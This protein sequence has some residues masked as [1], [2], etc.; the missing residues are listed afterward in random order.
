MHLDAPSGRA[1]LLSF[2]ATDGFSISTSILQC[3]RALCCIPTF[4][5]MLSNTT[6]RWLS[7]STVCQ[8]SLYMMLS[9]RCVAV[10][11]LSQP[12]ISSTSIGRRLESTST[13]TG[14]LV[15]GGSGRCGWVAREALGEW[16]WVKERFSKWNPGKWKHGLKPA[17]PGWFSF[18][19][20]PNGSDLMRHCL[21]GTNCRR[22]SGG[23]WAKV[24]LGVAQKGFPWLRLNLVAP[25][26]PVP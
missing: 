22:S 21:P 8:A 10:G 15:L 9:I 26:H 7:S 24:R 19:P 23:I 4:Q 1:S 12:W 11:I 18:H 20:C 16:K 25:S 17:V 5:T 14:G 13:K 6:D 3:S 2:N